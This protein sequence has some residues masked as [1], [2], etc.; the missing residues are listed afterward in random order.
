MNAIHHAFI[1]CTVTSLA[2]STSQVVKFKLH[3][4]INYSHISS[5]FKGKARYRYEDNIKMVLSPAFMQ[6]LTKATKSWVDRRTLDLPFGGDG[7]GVGINE[8]W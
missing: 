7:K 8:K 4:T 3:V 5:L 6:W 1:A 2:L